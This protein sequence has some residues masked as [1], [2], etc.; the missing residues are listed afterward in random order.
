ME[1]IGKIKNISIENQNDIEITLQTKNKTLLEELN[2]LQ[3]KQSEINV[4]IKKKSLK[5]SLDS[6]AYAWHLMEEIAKVIGSD[7][8][9]VYEDML[10]KYGVFTHLVVKPQVVDRIKEA[11]KVVRVLGEV[12]INGSTGVQLQCYFGSSTYTQSEM[13]RF[14]RGITNECRDLKI[15]TLE[16]SEINSMIKEWGI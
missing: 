15:P 6:N 1:F 4:K 7:K 10:N 3:Q 16:D 9:L 14:I 11:W 8:D 5:R 12:K 13:S 2:K